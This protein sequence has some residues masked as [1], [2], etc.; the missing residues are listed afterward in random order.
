MR[1][2][3]CVQ[4]G[5]EKPTDE[6]AGISAAHDVGTCHVCQQ[7]LEQHNRQVLD[8]YTWYMRLFDE[9]DHAASE[10]DL[11]FCYAMKRA[12]KEHEYPTG[13]VVYALVDPR[14]DQVRYVGQ[15][16][17]PQQRLRQHRHRNTTNRPKDAWMLELRALGLEPQMRILEEVADTDFV[18]ERER[19]W[20]LQFVHDGADLLNQELKRR[21]NFVR[22]V[23]RL[24]CKDFLNEPRS[25]RALFGF[26]WPK[27]RDIG[28]TWN[29]PFPLSTAVYWCLM[30]CR[31]K[32]P[33]HLE[34]A[35]RQLEDVAR[36]LGYMK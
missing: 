13:Q 9:I 34:D 12:W 22:D 7:K 6:F 18:L 36:R 32:L 16:A 19:R 15:T 30:L 35:A 23:R 33:A 10:N 24:K 3:Y 11:D 29:E 17:Q 1:M 31:D 25:S 20:L 14:T 21:P 27:I 26:N 2:V 4:C 8:D 28:E 5:M